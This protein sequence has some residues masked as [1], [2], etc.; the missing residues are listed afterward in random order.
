ML[1]AFCI[2]INHCMNNFTH[3]QFYIIKTSSRKN[4]VMQQQSYCKNELNKK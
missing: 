2:E 3:C 1:T 4:H